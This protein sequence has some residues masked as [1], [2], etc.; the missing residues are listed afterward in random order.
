MDTGEGLAWFFF[1]VVIS[2]LFFA[3]FGS[4]NIDEATIEEY[5]ARLMEQE[6]DGGRR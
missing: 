6:K 3:A 5:M 1:L 4:S 2:I